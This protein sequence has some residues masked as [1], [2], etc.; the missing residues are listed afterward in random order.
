MT[1]VSSAPLATATSAMKAKSWGGMLKPEART[2]SSNGADVAVS[3]SIDSTTEAATPT[4]IYTMPAVTN[5]ANSA[6]GY[7]LRTPRISSAR[8]PRALSSAITTRNIRA[9]RCGGTS[10]NAAR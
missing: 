1:M 7:T 4:A 9:A 5:A 10:T 2:T 8:I 6:R 3:L